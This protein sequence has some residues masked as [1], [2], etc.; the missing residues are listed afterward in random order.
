MCLLIGNITEM[1][2]LYSAPTDSPMYD[3][4]AIPGP[5]PKPTPYSSVSYN[6]QIPHTLPISLDDLGIHIASCHSGGNAGFA[7]QYKVNVILTNF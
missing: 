7:E 1:K 4:V 3:T 5:P 2:C 6:P